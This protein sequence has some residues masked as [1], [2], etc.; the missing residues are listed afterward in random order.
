MENARFSKVPKEVF[1][2]DPLF[3][4]FNMIARGES[5]TEVHV[6]DANVVTGACKSMRFVFLHRPT[7]EHQ[8]AASVKTYYSVMRELNR[9]M[10]STELTG[11]TRE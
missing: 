11:F 6:I 10:Y 7:V 5:Q 8:L 2:L 3:E 4:R 1:A 9:R